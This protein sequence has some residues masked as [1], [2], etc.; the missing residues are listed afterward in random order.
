[1][2]SD[3]DQRVGAGTVART[4]VRRSLLVKRLDER[5]KKLRHELAKVEAKREKAD[6]RE[7][8]RVQGDEIFATLHELGD[9][10]RDEAKDAAAKLFSQYKKLGASIPH[11]E[12][13]AAA[14]ARSLASI[15]ELR[16]EAERT[17]DADFADVERAAAMLDPRKA[18][19]PQ[20]V[21]KKKK[22]APLEFRTESGSRIL[23]GRSPSE[24]AE[25]T[26]HVARPHDLWFHAQNIPGAHVILQRDDRDA[27][28]YDDI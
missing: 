13:R 18:A 5:E 23:V 28:G 3:R 25:L 8:M 7:S 15:E 14:I 26:F 20:T 6:A 2:K 16:W 10:Q 4:N 1:L 27:P 9:A 19:S 11:L 21:R 12:E 24:N 17:D 22:R